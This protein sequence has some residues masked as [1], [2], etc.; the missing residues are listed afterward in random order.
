MI[1]IKCKKELPDGSLFCCWCGK[2][3]KPE[4][5]KTRRRARGSGTISKDTRY[6][7]QWRAIAP[8]V[9]KGTSGKCIGYFATVKEAQQALE[10]YL[11]DTRP[12][13]YNI[14]LDKLYQLWSDKHFEALTDS[15]VAGYTS[16]YVN[17]APLHRR[18]MRELKTADFQKCID[19]IAEKYSR[20]KLEKVR[21][22]CSQLCKFAMQNDI[23]DKN[24]A[25]FITLPKE[26][27]REK[28]IFTAD[29]IGTLWSHSSENKV[30]FVLFLLYTGFRIGEVSAIASDDI[31]L[32]EGYIVGG[33]KTKAGKNRVV[34]LPPS[35][36]EIAGFVRDWL[37]APDNSP[38]GVA[39]ASLRQYWF[40]PTLAA[41]GLIEPPIFNKKNK[42]QEYKDPR[43]T[44]HSTRHT[45]ASL[46]AAAGMRPDALQKIIGHADYATTAEIYV[47]KNIE[48]LIEEM[49]RL[50]K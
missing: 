11:S 50:K 36:P 44:P 48:T 27:K 39:A 4:Q 34:P 7:N 20:S 33:I 35:I 2:R 22:L 16:A 40:Y 30:R 13:I 29:D 17:L 49:R 28:G 41:L 23:M 47:H 8:P 3:Q 18:K 1:C 32:A 15:G 38:F 31:H 26:E 14:T 6:K 25:Q 12:D 19:D 9:I 37:S 45:F 10:A 42:K 5:K 21:Q 24:Y 43:L 46:S